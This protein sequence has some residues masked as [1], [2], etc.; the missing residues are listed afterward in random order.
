M[1]DVL[2]PCRI[3]DW[4]GHIYQQEAHTF[5]RGLW[6]QSRPPRPNYYEDE[7]PFMAKVNMYTIIDNGKVPTY[8]K[9]TYPTLRTFAPEMGYRPV[10]DDVIL[11]GPPTL[12]FLCAILSHIY[13]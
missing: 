2:G 8:G 11:S 12:F 5:P 6:N 4:P 3:F 7:H 1:P 13:L 9:D 10:T